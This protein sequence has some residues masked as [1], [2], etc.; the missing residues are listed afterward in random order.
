MQFIAP[1]LKELGYLDNLFFNVAVVGSRKLGG[2][3][4]I[5]QAQKC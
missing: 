4:D 1:I 3:G 5:D 2:L